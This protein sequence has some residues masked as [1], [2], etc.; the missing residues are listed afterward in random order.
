MWWSAC[1]VSKFLAKIDWLCMH[2]MVVRD[3]SSVLIVFGHFGVK[4]YF[5]VCGQVIIIAWM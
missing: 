1:G 2:I 3:G 4:L 5:I